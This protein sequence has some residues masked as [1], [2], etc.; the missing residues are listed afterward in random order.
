[1]GRAVALLLAALAAFGC[2]RRSAA[3][4]DLA[5]VQAA[6][7]PAH[8]SWDMDM[9]VSEDGR[10]RFRLRAEHLAYYERKDSTYMVLDG[11]GR[12]SGVLYDGERDTTAWF[13][14]DRMT[15]FEDA[16]RMEARGRVVVRSANG[17]VLESEHLEW[18]ESARRVLTPGFARVTL[19]D[20]HLEGYGLTARE[21]LEDV[22]LATVTGSVT[23]TDE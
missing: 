4:V 16:R 2:S 21:D 18:L 6:E 8:E 10:P 19:V 22:R 15:W 9:L 3:P 1:M 7:G 14:A 13:E 20:G 17:R 23:V 5:E 11:A 12:V